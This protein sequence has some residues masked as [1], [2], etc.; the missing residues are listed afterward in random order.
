[1][2]PS[3]VT[4]FVAVPETTKITLSWLAPVNRPCN[5]VYEVSVKARGGDPVPAAVVNVTST[6][7]VLNDVKAGVTYDIVVTVRN[8]ALL[9]GGALH[10][11]MVPTAHANL[12][13]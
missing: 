10:R 8:G 12:K 7:A 11:Q 2:A 5:V 13:R 1:M 4:G 3:G 6:R 9:L